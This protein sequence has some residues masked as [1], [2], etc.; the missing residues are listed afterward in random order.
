MPIDKKIT[1]GKLFSSGF[2]EHYGKAFGGVQ[3]EKNRHKERPGKKL[4]PKVFYD[5]ETFDN[6]FHGVF[7]N[8]I[9][10]GGECHATL[11]A[12]FIPAYLDYAKWFTAKLTNNTLAGDLLRLRRENQRLAKDINGEIK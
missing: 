3:L 9:D 10:S 1:D 12:V 7:H 4:L 5:L 11:L 2:S 6:G 8:A